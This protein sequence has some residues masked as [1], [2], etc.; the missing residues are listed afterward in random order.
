MN[1]ASDE[2]GSRH[3]QHS[4]S[5]LPFRLL[6]SVLHSFLDRLTQKW[7]KMVCYHPRHKNI[8]PRRPPV[9]CILHLDPPGIPEAVLGAG[10]PA[11]W[12]QSLI[13]ASYEFA[14]ERGALQPGPKE[15]VSQGTTLS[16]CGMLAPS[17][18]SA[19]DAGLAHPSWV[20]CSSWT[21]TSR[22]RS[23]E[24]VLGLPG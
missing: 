23:R 6:P 7:G 10:V 14:F 22:L 11:F 13:T 8:S 24:D 17:L 15:A 21:S 3:S 5:C 2:A 1:L 19:M 20:A 18:A 4:E 16:F 12:L 9:V